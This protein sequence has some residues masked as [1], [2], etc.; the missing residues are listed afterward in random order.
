MV[1]WPQ[2]ISPTDSAWKQV[3]ALMRVLPLDPRAAV[4]KG[5][6]PRPFLERSD[7][8]LVRPEIWV[9]RRRVPAPYWTYTLRFGVS[10]SVHGSI[11]VEDAEQLM[12]FRQVVDAALVGPLTQAERKRWE[13]DTQ[14]RRLCRTGDPM[15]EIYR[16]QGRQAGMLAHRHYDQVRR[17]IE[18]PRRK[19]GFVAASLS[20]H[21]EVLH[22]L[23]ELGA[24]VAAPPGGSIN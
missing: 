3:C 8:V 5:S 19:A 6:C 22:G 9:D 17:D 18:E 10:A 1:I 23:I 12:E 7:D 11:P 4:T 2:T 13:A 21:E 16:E 15:A 20:R 14:F 24:P